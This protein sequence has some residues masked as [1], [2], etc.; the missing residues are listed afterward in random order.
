MNAD[1]DEI[2]ALDWS[3]LNV[4]YFPAPQSRIFLP[5]LSY[6]VMSVE[7]HDPNLFALPHSVAKALDVWRGQRVVATNCEYWDPKLV[8]LRHHFFNPPVCFVVIIDKNL[9]VT[10]I[11][12]FE[13]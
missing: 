12:Q 1:L 8:E 3:P 7:I 5:P 2:L 10:K 6:I 13:S 4:Q 11:T 9:N